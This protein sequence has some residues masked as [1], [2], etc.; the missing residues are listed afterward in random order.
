[1]AAHVLAKKHASFDGHDS[2][3]QAAHEFILAVRK[4]SEIFIAS[5]WE[6]DAKKEAVSTA[7][8]NGKL[9]KEVIMRD[10]NFAPSH[11]LAEEGYKVGMSVTRKV[12]KEEIGII[13][14]INVE[15]LNL[16]MVDGKVVIVPILSF[17]QHE[18][19]I[20]VVK[21]K[22]ETV[23]N[24]LQHV[25]HLSQETSV[26]RIKAMVV[27][28]LCALCGKHADVLKSLVIQTKPRKS[29][30]VSKPF[31]NAKLIL[32][33]MTLKIEAVPKN[34]SK[35]VKHPRCYLGPLKTNDVDPDMIFS[36]APHATFPTKS[37]GGFISPF[38]LVDTTAVETLAN[39]VIKTDNKMCESFKKDLGVNLPYMVNTRALKENEFLLIFIP[40]T[41]PEVVELVECSKA[42]K[43]KLTK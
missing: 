6:A 37:Q 5:P 20:T 39:M 17:L 38:W 25:G 24:W 2:I 43:P 42:K 26:M 9:V 8:V 32:L 41:E 18:W 30:Q 3:G 15:N 31:P 7:S 33:P 21:P 14:S 4:K 29:V 16:R 35:D 11:A 23:A 27:E 1:V 13:E 28:K 12:N 10:L 34:K 36:L 40:K 22:P 19:Y